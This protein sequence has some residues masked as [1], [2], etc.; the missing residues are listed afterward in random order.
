MY[1]IF[2]E[3][4]DPLGKVVTY[5][6]TQ[7]IQTIIASI[8]VGCSCNVDIN[9][10]LAPYSFEAK[11]L[12]MERF[13]DQLEINRFLKLFDYTSLEQL[14][15]VF[16]LMAGACSLASMTPEKVDIDID[17]TGLIANGSSFQF[18]RKGYFSKKQGSS[19]YQLNM[20]I[21][22]KTKDILVCSL[23]PGDFST[24]SEFSELIYA[25]VERLGGS[26]DRLGLVR[27]DAGYGIKN[28]LE[29]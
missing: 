5:T 29:F 4:I 10:R 15:C 11:L 24:P 8:V 27:A 20:V 7:K 2:F 12:N 21:A 14:D 28:N 18:N 25:T 16:S 26:F 13:P 19:G 3:L 1:L 6:T 23:H 22:S 9:Y 17:A